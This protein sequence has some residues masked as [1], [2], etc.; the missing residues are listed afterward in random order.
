MC[1]TVVSNKREREDPV[2]SHSRGNSTDIYIVTVTKL[3]VVLLLTLS[4]IFLS[5]CL[6][7]YRVCSYQIT[8]II[9]NVPDVVVV[10]VHV[11]VDQIDGRNEKKIM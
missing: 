2:P 7:F 8:L 10:H 4:L 1:S 3:I 9:L 6:D 5:S 11:D